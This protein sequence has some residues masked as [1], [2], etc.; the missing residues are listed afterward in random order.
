MYEP[1]VVIEGGRRRWRGRDLD[2]SWQGLLQE[3]PLVLIQV[4]G[5]ADNE[6]ASVIRTEKAQNALG[7]FCIAIVYP[8]DG[9]TATP[10][11]FN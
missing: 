10:K 3:P 2:S 8:I 4:T 9:G 6:T 7:L 1:A 11:K 5:A